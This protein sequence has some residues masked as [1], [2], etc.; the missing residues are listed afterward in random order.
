MSKA[1]IAE[2]DIYLDEYT[3]GD[4]I[5]RYI[6]KSAGAGIA[7][8]L[9]KIYGPIYTRCIKELIDQAPRNHKFRIMEYGCGGGMN[10]IK[11]AELVRGEAVLLEKVYGTDFSAPMI[12]AAR[13]EAVQYLPSS[14]VDTVCYCVARNERLLSDFACNTSVASEK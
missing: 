6:A 7:Y 4:I 5:D 11:L 13:R 8:V 3:R 12:E 9:E 2:K 1:T 14:L 10:L